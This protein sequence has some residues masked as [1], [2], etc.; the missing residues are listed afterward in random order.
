MPPKKWWP[1]SMTS[2]DEK[3]V[4][5]S[6]VAAPARHPQVVAALPL[7]RVA[8]LRAGP[9]QGRKGERQPLLR[10]F[11]IVRSAW[12]CLQYAY[13]INNKLSTAR[14]HALERSNLHGGS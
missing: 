5:V 9:L 2:S 13:Q 3:W 11:A 7:E 8:A 14:P 10:A 6:A 4:R 12:T 1:A